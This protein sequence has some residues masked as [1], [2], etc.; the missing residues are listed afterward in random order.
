MAENQN[1]QANGKPN[2]NFVLINYEPPK[3]LTKEEVASQWQV[4]KDTLQKWLG[5]MPPKEGEVKEDEATKKR[6][7]SED[8]IKNL[9]KKYRPSLLEEKQENLENGKPLASLYEEIIKSKEEIIRNLESQN[10][11]LKEEVA[12][13]RQANWQALQT[14][15]R[16]IREWQAKW[17]GYILEQEDKKK[18]EN[19]VKESQNYPQKVLEWV[20]GF[21]KPK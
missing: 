4:S 11:Y 14:L 3:F 18:L 6:L 17:Q 12:T 9:F 7:Y 21:F 16:E 2:Q 10:Y 8:Y 15:S 20:K 13:Q 5:K 1:W 19:Q